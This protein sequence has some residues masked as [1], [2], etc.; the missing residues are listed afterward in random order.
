MARS[1]FIF[2]MPGLVPGISIH[3]AVPFVIEM[4]GTS[5]AMTKLG[6]EAVEE[7]FCCLMVRS[8]AKHRVSNHARLALILRDGAFRASSG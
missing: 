6:R 1:H 7:D 3:K 4:A 2:V 5:P 8:D